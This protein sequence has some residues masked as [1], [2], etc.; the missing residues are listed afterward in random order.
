MGYPG[1]VGRKGEAG[2]W[3]PHGASGKRGPEG[4]PGKRGKQGP[5]GDPG[6]PGPVG[7]P[8]PSGLT[9]Q[10]GPPGLPGSG[11]Y[12][13]GEKGDMGVPG[14]PGR[15][16]CNAARGNTPLPA[17]RPLFSHA[18]VP[19]IFVVDDENELE[20]LHTDDAL[21]FR[22]DQHTLYYRDTNG[23]QPVQSS[24]RFP[25]AVGWCG[26]GVLQPL[27]GEECDDGNRIITDSCIECRRAFCGDGHRHEGMEECDGK[28]FGRQTCKT[29]LP[30][31]VTAQTHR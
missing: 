1:P 23:W 10:P 11:L 20:Q 27:N 21:A 12:L 29:Y 16:Y 24:D 28:D 19:A 4:R 8:G 15:C 6:D 7:P 2:D 31:C 9:G 26:D 3:G 13:V 17:P 5:E 30:G 25:D 22:K 18:Q 14:P